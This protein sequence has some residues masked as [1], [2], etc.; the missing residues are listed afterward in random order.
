MVDEKLLLEELVQAINTWMLGNKNRSLSS[1]ARKANVAYSTIRRIAQNESVPHPYT[2]LAIAE[3][4]YTVD[5]RIDFLKKHFPI[6]GNLM[7]ECYNGKVQTLPSEGMLDQFLRKEPHN[8][9]FNMAA[10]HAGTNRSVIQRLTGEFGIEALEEMLN[11]GVILESDTGKIHYH[12]EHWAYG[13]FDEAL[14]QTRHSV[15]H[16]N[17]Q[18]IGTAGAS[19]MHATGSVNADTVPKLKNLINAFVKEFNAIKNA[20]DAEGSIPFF[21]DLIYSLYDKNDLIVK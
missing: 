10:T 15:G 16:F 12:Q 6:V 17:K 5:Q 14:E 21:C 7:E 1:L 18:L 2:A 11:A 8:R 3:V 20:K 19:L 9:I 13:S 4:V